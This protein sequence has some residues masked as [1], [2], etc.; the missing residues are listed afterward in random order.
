M[1]L[2]IGMVQ[3]VIDNT[4]IGVNLKPL[5]KHQSILFQTHAVT[6]LFL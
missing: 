4:S 3:R 2:T 6:E 1:D 5:I